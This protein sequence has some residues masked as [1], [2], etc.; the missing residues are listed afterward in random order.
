MPPSDDYVLAIDLGTSAL[1][2]ALVTTQGELADAV[3]WMDSRGADQARRVTGG[4]PKVEG[5]GLGRLLRWIHRTGGVPTHSGKDSIAHILW[6]KEEWPD[7]YRATATFLEPR[8]WLNLRL[9]GRVA[10]TVDSITLHWV[11]DNRR[12]DRVGYHPRL[13]AMAGLDRAKLPNLLPASSVL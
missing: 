6:I 5:Y 4:F 9:T 10:A 7:V 12:I 2:L 3:I 11:T 8:D 13:L 1:K